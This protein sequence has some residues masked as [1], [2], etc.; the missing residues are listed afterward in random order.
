MRIIPMTEQFLA[1]AGV[2]HSAAW[3]Q[4]HREI[5]TPEFVASHTP[6]RQTEYLRKEQ[7]AGKK[8][9]LLLDDTETAVG[10][11][12]LDKRG[13]MGI[14]ENLYVLPAAQNRGFGTRLLR[15]AIQ[16][17]GTLYS[18]PVRPVLWVLSSNERAKRL[19]RRIGFAETGR[20]KPLRSG[21]CEQEMALE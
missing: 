3:Q 12:S 9:W 2:V 14:I 18:R 8:L 17:C 5:C 21:L 11:V 7:Q 20:S 16:K 10:V 19:Y 6:Q 1:A 4:S 13:T 15:F